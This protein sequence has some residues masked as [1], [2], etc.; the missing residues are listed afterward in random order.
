MQG[1]TGAT[2]SYQYDPNGNL[3]QKTENGETWVYVW[4]AENQLIRVCK[5]L[6]AP[7]VCDNDGVAVA[8][9]SYGPSGRRV[10]TNI[11]GT[12]TRYVFDVL[13]VLREW[14]GVAPPRYYI[15]GPG[16]L[17]EPLRSES[18]STGER[19]NHADGLGSIV[20][21]SDA[22]GSVVS[23]KAYDAWGLPATSM[24]SGYAFT[25]REWDASTSLY[26]YRARYY[27]PVG[28]RFLSEDP[29]RFKAGVNF[30]G[31]VMGNPVN[32]VDPMGWKEAPPTGPWPDLPPSIKKCFCRMWKE[33]NEGNTPFEAGATVYYNKNTSDFY[34]VHHKFDPGFGPGGFGNRRR[35]PLDPKATAHAH[36]HP[37][38]RSREPSYPGD[39]EACEKL[40][41][42]V[43]TDGGIYL[44]PQGCGKP[45][46]R[47]QVADKDWPDE[48]E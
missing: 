42:Y 24:A 35:I 32:Y 1:V 16:M 5:D 34:C 37:N 26:Y 39:Y 14:D 30:Y 12:V 11:G 46:C 21:S 31:Y 45:K 15:Q 4:N 18:V 27:D 41:G 33:A 23:T 19:Y 47:V 10:S 38:N 6:V 17:D 44:I 9:F 7:Q 40:P 20:A 3:T 2:A 36:T 25:G 22:G 48:C 13:D 43:L 8:G 28:G 29:L